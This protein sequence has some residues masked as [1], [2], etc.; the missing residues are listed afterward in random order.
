MV[1]SADKSCKDESAV[2]V[3]TDQLCEVCVWTVEEEGVWTGWKGAVRGG[4]GVGCGG[5]GLSFEAP[6][7]FRSGVSFG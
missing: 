4:V 5:E 3:V 2:V 6:G 1:V 7:L